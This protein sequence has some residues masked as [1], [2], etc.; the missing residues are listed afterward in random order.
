MLDSDPVGATW[1]LAC[2]RPQRDERGLGRPPWWPAT[3]DLDPDVTGAHDGKCSQAA[4][5][6]LY[7][8]IG[9]E[10][11]GS[12]RPRLLVAQCHVGEKSPAAVPGALEWL[13]KGTVNGMDQGRCA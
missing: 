5:H 12:H 3:E 7:T 2:A 9:F 1:G 13:T 8:D 11:E 10:I 4:L 6:D